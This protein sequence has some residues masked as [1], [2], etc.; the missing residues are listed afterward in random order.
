MSST[1]VVLLSN[2]VDS[3]IGGTRPV[4]RQL[5]LKFTLFFGL[6]RYTVGGGRGS[7]TDCHA[8]AV[9]IFGR[10]LVFLV[11][12]VQKGDSQKLIPAIPSKPFEQD[13]LGKRVR[14]IVLNLTP[15]LQPPLPDA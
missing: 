9:G 6:H 14:L 1:S 5:G 10:G 13:W 8:P 7:L 3:P 12:V 15:P 2:E 4:Y 11:T